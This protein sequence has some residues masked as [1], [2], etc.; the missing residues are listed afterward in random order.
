MSGLLV[1]GVNTQGVVIIRLGGGPRLPMYE[2]I[3]LRAGAGEYATTAYQFLEDGVSAHV[4][5]EGGGGGREQGGLGGGRGVWR[6]DY[7]V[8][9]SFGL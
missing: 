4:Q 3:H 9:G 6:S 8:L 2:P 5:N 1:H 7:F